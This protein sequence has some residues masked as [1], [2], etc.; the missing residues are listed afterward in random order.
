MAAVF[1]WHAKERALHRTGQLH[2]RGQV[3]GRV[4]AMRIDGRSV[5]RTRYGPK[6]FGMLLES[7]RTAGSAD[8]ALH[9]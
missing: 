5:D 8:N 1:F 3:F 2:G 9:H 4:D 7:A 6:G